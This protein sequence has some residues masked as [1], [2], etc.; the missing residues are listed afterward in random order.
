MESKVTYPQSQP[1]LT[2][3]S[4]KW[5]VMVESEPQ[6]PTDSDRYDATSFTVV[7]NEE[8]AR[9]RSEL[10]S[11]RTTSAASGDPT[12]LMTSTALMEY[13]LYF[14]AQESLKQG[15]EVSPA[16]QA[17]W[18]LLMETYFHMKLWASRE[19]AR[20]VSES[21]SPTADIVRRINLRR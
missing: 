15:L 11:L 17:L 16:D 1:E 6:V 20:Q 13:K 8:A 10:E 18:S 4:Y 5:E 12:N 7:N 2:P 21:A 14:Q 19:K 9:I 3:G